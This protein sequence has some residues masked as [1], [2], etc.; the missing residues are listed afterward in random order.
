MANIDPDLA[1]RALIFAEVAECGSFTAAAVHLRLSK[2]TVSARVRELESRLETQLLTRTTRAVRLTDEGAAFLESVL[3][4]REHWVDAVAWLATRGDEPSGVLRVT[5]PVT[6]CEVLVSPVLCE[7][8]ATFPRL[9]IE[10]IPDD[11]N[12]DLVRDNID[13][14]IRVGELADS[15][16]VGQRVG[17]EHGWVAVGR[18]SRW[19]DALQGPPEEQLQQLLEIPWVGSAGRRRNLTLTPRDG[20]DARELQ[21]H[22]RAWTQSSPGLLSLVRQGAGAAVLPDSMMHAGGADVRVVLPSYTAE[23]YSLWALR[24][25]RRHTP[26][27]VVAFAERIRDRLRTPLY[28]PP[29]E[30][31]LD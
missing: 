25:S 8:L 27:R 6:L 29:G 24:P 5:A 26:S 20:G 9:A 22:H 23:H 28:V 10:L 12:L 7:M 1:S 14:A 15:S 18:G 30:G 4:M 11:R 16:W 21:V 19:D 13:L 2:S 3:R 17:E 31:E